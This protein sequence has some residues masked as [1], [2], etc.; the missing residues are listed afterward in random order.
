[1]YWG[2]HDEIRDSFFSNAYQHKPGAYD[3]DIQPSL[4]T[5]SGER[6]AKPPL[7]VTRWSEIAAS[8]RRWLGAGR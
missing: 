1:M 2:Y 3:S 5:P 8:A 6:P 4:P 7:F